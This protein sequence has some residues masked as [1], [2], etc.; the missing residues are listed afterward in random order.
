MLAEKTWLSKKE[1]QR[2]RDRAQNIYQK[3]K[4]LTL[5]PENDKLRKSIADD[6]SKYNQN[7]NKARNIPLITPASI[8][9]QEA[10]MAKPTTK[11][12]GRIQKGVRPSVGENDIWAGVLGLTEELDSTQSEIK[13][14]VDL[15]ILTYSAPPNR[16]IEVMGEDITLTDEQYERYV[17][18]ANRGAKEYLDK[19]IRSDKWTEYGD[20][21]RAKIIK[22]IIKNK[23]K[24]ARNK[25]KFELRREALESRKK[26]VNY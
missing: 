22:N 14:L 19:M 5:N 16:S 4:T 25:I 18:D 6:I 12:R 21:V 3:V 17:T 10:H 26:A 15:D 7:A 13:R 23:R 20:E 9:R 1:E 8:M 24:I 11:E 2:F